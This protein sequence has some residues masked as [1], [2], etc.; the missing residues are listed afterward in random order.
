MERTKI[1]KFR[2][3]IKLIVISS[4]I[5]ICCVPVSSAVQQYEEHYFNHF[6]PHGDLDFCD[7]GHFVYY[8]T[9]VLFYGS[10]GYIL[11]VTLIS[12]LVFIKAIRLFLLT[13]KQ[14]KIIIGLTICQVLLMIITSILVYNVCL[15]ALN[16]IILT[17]LIWLVNLGVTYFL[18]SNS[19]KK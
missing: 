10:L 17:I 13:D 15:A 11:L 7:K 2:N 12:I 9:S 3:R 16:T 14:K 1:D 6:H 18:S 4:L 8:L 19:L 5:A